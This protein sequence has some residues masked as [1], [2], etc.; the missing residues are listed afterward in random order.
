MQKFWQQKYCTFQSV[1]I[2][3]YTYLF[4]LDVKKKKEKKGKIEIGQSFDHGQLNRVAN[5]RLY[6]TRK[7]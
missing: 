3:I 2:Y 1:Y 5:V 7:I 6:Y 4:L